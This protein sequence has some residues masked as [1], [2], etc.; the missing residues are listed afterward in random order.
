MRLVDCFIETMAFTLHFL[1]RVERDQPR[2][3]EV[4]AQYRELIT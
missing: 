3:N 4:E 1:E 2:Y